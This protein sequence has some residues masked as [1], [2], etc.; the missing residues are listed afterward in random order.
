M[1]QEIPFCLLLPGP[2]PIQPPLAIAILAGLVLVIVIVIIL[3]T[4]INKSLHP[5]YPG[6]HSYE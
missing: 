4:A 6:I 1:R 3:L 2:I 5:V